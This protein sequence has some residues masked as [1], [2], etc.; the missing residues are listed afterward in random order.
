M[1][2]EGSTLENQ[3]AETAAETAPVETAPQI[4]EIDGLSKFTFQGAEYTP[5]QLH[6]ML[7]EHK[8]Y[9]EQVKS[10]SED[11]KF[12]ENLDIDLDN[13]LKDPSLAQ[14]FKQT[15]PQKYHAILDKLLRDTG[16][17]AAPVTSAQTALPKEY[18]DRLN[19]LEREL[20]G[21]QDRLKFY[22]A[23]TFENETKL[24]DAKLDAILP[25]LFKKFPLANEDQVYTRAE[26]VLQSGQKL[27]DKTW[28]RLVRESH[29]GMTK[30][31]DQFYGT[32]MK[33][34]IAKGQQGRDTGSGGGSP[35][36][37]PTKPRTF[38]EAREAMIRH[39]A[40]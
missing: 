25:P 15:Y 29:E 19:K 37:V 22:D 39:Y 17:S 30:K 6:K 20:M 18:Q 33:E 11:R 36:N 8:S 14:R 16:Q 3:T 13:V 40:K 10:F 34:Q 9:A 28:E 1:G 27:T 24:A 2:I 38:D 12:S 21:T 23:K 31:S 32:K 26:G 35:G 7:G 4:T 5:D